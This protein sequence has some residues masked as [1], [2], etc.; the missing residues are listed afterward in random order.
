MI[1]EPDVFWSLPGPTWPAAWAARCSCGWRAGRPFD[2]LDDAET[3]WR[4]HRAQVTR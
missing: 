4:A 1:H 2:A 3:A